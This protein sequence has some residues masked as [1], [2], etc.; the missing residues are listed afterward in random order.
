MLH[1]GRL[2]VRA[3]ELARSDTGPRG[4]RLRALFEP[5]NPTIA[6][7]SGLLE[8]CKATVERY[9]GQ[10]WWRAVIVSGSDKAVFE[11]LDM[12]LDHASR[13]MVDEVQLETACESTGEGAGM[14]SVGSSS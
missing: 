4:Q 5:S 13:A 2:V 14:F 11:A 3:D 12:Q 9:S 10:S 6:E 1:V 7:V 8:A